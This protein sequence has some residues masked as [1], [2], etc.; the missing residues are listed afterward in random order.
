MS[1]Q[2]IPAS[3]S[4][5]A[6]D[7]WQQLTIPAVRLEVDEISSAMAARLVSSLVSHVLFLKSQIP[8]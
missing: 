1:H 6:K 8:L 4:Q 5:D 7:L 2:I 3:D